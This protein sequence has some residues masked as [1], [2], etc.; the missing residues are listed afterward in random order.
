MGDLSP[1]DTRA[2]AKGGAVLTA[3]A[4]AAMAIAA[5]GMKTGMRRVPMAEGG[6]IGIN[7]P[8]VSP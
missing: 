2:Q 7:P 3:R 1:S 4:S 6:P 8:E 5:V